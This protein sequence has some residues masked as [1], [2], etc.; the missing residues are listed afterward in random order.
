MGEIKL[1]TYTYGFKINR[2]LVYI[3]NTEYGYKYTISRIPI[4]PGDYMQS[5]FSLIFQ[6]HAS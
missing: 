6:D 4:K 2:M 3:A 5:F 1:K